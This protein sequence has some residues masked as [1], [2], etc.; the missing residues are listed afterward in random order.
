[1]DRT[2]STPVFLHAELLPNIR[3]ITLYISVPISSDTTEESSL[4]L[5]PKI[6]LSAS[7]RAITVSFPGLSEDSAETIKLPARVSDTSRRMLDVAKPRGQLVGNG[8][9]SHEKRMEFSLRMPVDTAE[10][11]L[12]S[13]EELTDGF[14]PWTAGDMS[15]RSEVRCRQCSTVFLSSGAHSSS[16]GKDTAIPGAKRGWVWKDLPS[17]NWAE[18]MDFWHCHKPDPRHSHDHGSDSGD[19][20]IVDDQQS[21]IKGYGAANQVVAIPGTVLVDVATFLVAEMDC[22]G[23]IKVRIDQDPDTSSKLQQHPIECG[24]CSS[25]IGTEDPVAQGWRLFKT[26]ISVVTKDEDGSL[27]WRAYPTETIVAAQLLELVERE[28]ARRFV[29]HCGQGPGLLLWTFNPDLR[30][31]SSGRDRSIAAQRAMKV[32][33]QQISDVD[34]LLYPETGK[35]TP[36]ALDELRLPT[37]TYT[38]LCAALA[39][40]NTML[41]M[42][43]RLFQD[44]TVGLLDRFERTNS[45]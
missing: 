31:S 19:V 5:D 2:E 18:M 27:Q 43:A 16:G 15:P 9:L 44:W 1:M 28:S 34:T 45:G 10:G 39:K 17:G 21:Q 7:R 32:L 20:G 40:T 35:A 42:S 37:K 8:G 33:F 3:Q 14:V 24:K 23:L 29:V 13:R 4:H 22:Q 12:V 25:I 38:D 6:T 41:P 36:L 11:P 26:H 30:Y